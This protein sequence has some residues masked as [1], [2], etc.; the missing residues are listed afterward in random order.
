M[1]ANLTLVGC[2]DRSVLPDPDERDRILLR[3]AKDNL[4][5]M[6]FFGLTEHQAEMRYLFEQTFGMQFR[7][8]FSQFADTHASKVDLSEEQLTALRSLNR[9]DVELYKYAS[10]LFADRVKRA[11]VSAALPAKRTDSVNQERLITGLSDV[12]NYKADDDGDDDGEVNDVRR[13][14]TAAVSAENN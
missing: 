11:K 4:R 10:E 14:G 5:Q 1:L 6:A 2:Y 3:S 7:R 9:L 13:L 12:N 8:D